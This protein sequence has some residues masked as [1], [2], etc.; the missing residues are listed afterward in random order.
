MKNNLI[1]FYTLAVYFIF[2][3]V[4]MAQEPGEGG[5]GVEGGANDNTGTA[6]ISD[7]LWVLAVV[8]LVFVYFKF[9]S[10]Q[11]NSIQA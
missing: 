9:R 2:T 4:M 11:K 3:A 5:S 7:H 10:I 1:K 8:G 6:P